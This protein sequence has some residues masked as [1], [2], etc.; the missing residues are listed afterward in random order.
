MMSL[1]VAFFPTSGAMTWFIHPAGTKSGI[2]RRICYDLPWMS[3][4]KCQGRS[5]YLITIITPPLTRIVRMFKSEL[6]SICEA[7]FSRFEVILSLIVLYSF[8]ISFTIP[9]YCEHIIAFSFIGIFKRH[10]M[11]SNKVWLKFQGGIIWTRW[12][13]ATP[14]RWRFWLSWGALSTWRSTKWKLVNT[15]SALQRRS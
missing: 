6:T 13:S 2:N 14:G 11:I 9:L 10:D 4:S 1:N 12:L 15:S 7:L 3:L 5:V 8:W